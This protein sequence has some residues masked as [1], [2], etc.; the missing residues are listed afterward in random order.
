MIG[1]LCFALA[2]LASPFKSTLRLTSVRDW[3]LGQRGRAAARGD[4]VCVCGS[5][6]DASRGIR[7]KRRQ[8][9]SAADGRAVIA[10]VCRLGIKTRWSILL[11]LSDLTLPSTI[12]AG[13]T[14]AGVRHWLSWRW[15]MPHYHFDIKDGHWTPRNL[16]QPLIGLLRSPPRKRAH[17]S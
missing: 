7:R 14:L 17:G 9:L 4:R 11:T 16:A 6:N 2:V 3:H 15:P 8:T 5:G 12:V 13:G 1:L 10:V